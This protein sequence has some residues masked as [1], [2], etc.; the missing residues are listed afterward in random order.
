MPNTKVDSM[1]QLTS[2]H[3]FV[4][5][6]TNQLS[7][8]SSNTHIYKLSSNKHTYLQKHLIS[9]YE[10]W[11]M[12]FL[13]IVQEF[14]GHFHFRL[15]STTSIHKFQSTSTSVDISPPRYSFIAC[16]C[17]CINELKNGPRMWGKLPTNWGLS[18]M[19]NIMKI[20]IHPVYIILQN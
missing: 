17:T 6:V 3:V 8:V 11:K 20:F 10:L 5:N 2:M 18:T 7:R 9:K 19:G 15:R 12:Y 13:I 16:A 4:V 1:A 14:V